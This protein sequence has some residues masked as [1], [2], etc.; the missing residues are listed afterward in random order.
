MVCITGLNKIT[1]HFKHAKAVQSFFDHQVVVRLKYSS[2][3]DSYPVQ[4]KPKEQISIS[5]NVYTR[6]TVRFIVMSLDMYPTYLLGGFTFTRIFCALQ[7]TVFM[8]Y[9]N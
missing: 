1:P 7:V 3:I 4:S 6:L 5:Y 2:N 9:A 8:F